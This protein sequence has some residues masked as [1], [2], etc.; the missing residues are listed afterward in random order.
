MEGMTDQKQLAEEMKKH[1]RMMDEM[2][3]RMMQQHMQSTPG[4]EPRP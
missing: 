4:E 3:E 1:M 2:V